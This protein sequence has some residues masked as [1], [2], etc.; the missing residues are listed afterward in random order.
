M[1]EQQSKLINELREVFQ[2][3]DYKLADI[4]GIQVTRFN[5]I[6]G[7]RNQMRM[8]LDEYLYGLKLLN[9]KKKLKPSEKDFYLGLKNE[10]N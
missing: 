10:R 3:P 8:R 6:K 2:E 9:Y 1:I 4:L 5:R 7:A